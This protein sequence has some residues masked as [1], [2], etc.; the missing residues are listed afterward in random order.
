M[1]NAEAA[2]SSLR[3]RV[4]S[5]RT[6]GLRHFRTGGVTFARGGGGVVPHYMPWIFSVASTFSLL[7]KVFIPLL[8]F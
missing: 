3:G 7:V 5:L 2:V 8:G 6:G 4:K 1:K